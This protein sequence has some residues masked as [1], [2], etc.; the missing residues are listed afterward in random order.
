[1]GAKI[2]VTGGLGYIGSHTCVSLIE[3]GYTPLVIDN[4]SRSDYEVRG[5]IGKIV[6]GEILFE[7]VEMCHLE[8]LSGVFERHLDIAGVI[9]FAAFLLVNESV[10]KPLRYYENNLISTMNL[11]RCMDKYGVS[12]IVFS[13]SCTVYGNPDH[14]PAGEDAPVKEAGSP[15]GNTKKIGEDILRDFSKVSGINVVS[16]RYFNPIEA[17][18]TSIIGEFQD[19]EPHHLVPYITQTAMGKRAF[20]RVF[21]GDY[22]T[23]DGSC[24]RDYIHVEDIAEAHILA[25]QRLINRKNKGDFEVFNLGSGNGSTV[26]EMIKAFESATGIRLAYRIVDRRPGDVE[27]VYAD[28][29]KAREV[30]GWEPKRSL[31]EMLVSAWNFEKALKEQ[32]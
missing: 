12:P 23:R 13:S 11:A 16:L 15:Y 28:I 22:N 2:L 32:T 14:L 6:G 7:Q 18:K 27:A 10:D 1:M 20:L 29:S 3:Q 9:H 31:E 24:I 30:L 26:L 17:H 4:L 25:V 19:G 5:R 8:E 21:G